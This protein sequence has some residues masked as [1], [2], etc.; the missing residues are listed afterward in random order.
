MT[1]PQALQSSLAASWL[2]DGRRMAALEACTLAAE[3]R[4]D[5]KAGNQPIT[6]LSQQVDAM[7]ALTEAEFWT[8]A[9]SSTPALCNLLVRLNR[10]KKTI[11]MAARK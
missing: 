10:I 2:A 11:E 9:E 4:E 7:E 5:A 8:L 6:Q 1:Q 3:R